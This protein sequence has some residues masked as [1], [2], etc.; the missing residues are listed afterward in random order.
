MIL[1]VIAIV[2]LMKTGPNSDASTVTSSKALLDAGAGV[3]CLSWVL[4]LVWAVWSF[5]EMTGN[6]AYN[7]GT[8]ATQGKIVSASP[9]NRP[10]CGVILTADFWIRLQLL[11]AVFAVLPFIAIRLG[12]A[13]AF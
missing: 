5:S 6:A 12:Y 3:A 7:N 4:L 9:C 8:A 2:K 11:F 13:I 1:I 10:S